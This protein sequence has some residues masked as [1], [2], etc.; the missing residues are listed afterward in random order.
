MRRRTLVRVLAGSLPVAIAGCTGSADDDTGSTDSNGEPGTD[1]SNGASDASDDD[2]TDPGEPELTTLE[3]I[4]AAADRYDDDSQT[5]TG[6]GSEQTSEFELRDSIT[7][8]IAEH[9]GDGQFEPELRNE[10]RLR[11]F[12]PISE[13]GSY[14][15]TAA[16]GVQADTY[17]LDV[18]AAGDWSVEIAQPVSPD[19][20]IHQLP[21]EVSGDGQDVVGPVELTGEATVTGTHDGEGG[22]GV[23][24]L[25]ESGR[26]EHGQVARVFNEVDEFDGQEAIEM[27]AV[28]WIHVHAEA[29]WT[30][31]IE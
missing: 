16:V 26:G 15:G 30:I 13:F 1:D 23:E 9:D 4:T 11:A 7:V 8:F 10:S 5:F 19:E 21:V 24:V 31:E 28:C 22:F 14:A 17:H 18:V 2:S 27:N 6:S 12:L 20:V 25:D 3:S 29:S